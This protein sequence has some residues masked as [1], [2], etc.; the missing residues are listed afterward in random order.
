[1]PVQLYCVKA[2]SKLRVRVSS[3]GYLRNANCQFPRDLRVNGR[4]YEVDDGAISLITTRGKYFY[5][6]KNRSAI[7]VLSE[8][9]AAVPIPAKPVKKPDQIYTDETMEDCIVCMEKPKEIVFAPCGHFYACDG[10]SAGMKQCPI[11]RC[12][13]TGRIKSS[14]FGTDE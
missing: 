11:C 6:V 2:G 4:K 5:A 9:E 10:C 3:E 14:E 8:T 12:A 13:I 1:M 7:R